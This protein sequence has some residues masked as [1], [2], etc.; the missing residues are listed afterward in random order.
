[1]PRKSTALLYQLTRRLRTDP[2]QRSAR[3]IARARLERVT[4]A[5][6]R[7]RAG[8]PSGLHDFRVG[9]RRLRTWLKA[10]RP[11]LEDTVKRRMRRALG[12]LADVTNA[13]RDAEI[14]LAWASSDEAVSAPAQRARKLLREQYQAELDAATDVAAQHLSRKVEK[15]TSDLRDAL[16]H[17]WLRVAVTKRRR[18]PPMG[19]VMGNLLRQQADRLARAVARVESPADVDESHRARIAAK[20]LRYLLEALPADERVADLIT[21]LTALQDALGEFHDGHLI[22]ERIAREIADTA[23]RTPR[24]RANDDGS[25]PASRT[26]IDA[27]L[28]EL[29][30][31]VHLQGVRAFETFMTNRD[32]QGIVATVATVAEAVRAQ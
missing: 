32:V 20:H 2:A 18:E 7:Y 16:E 29:A 13:A 25:P 27:G 31:R 5:Y 21:R 3:R 8:D 15:T 28:A 14:G 30:E 17:Y 22:V 11:E 6:Q 19:I 23:K 24:D 4:E 9:L 10:F 1:M 12:K 26:R